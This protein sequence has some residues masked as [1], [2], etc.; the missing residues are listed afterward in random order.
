MIQLG[1]HRVHH[2]DCVAWMRALPANIADAIV[3]DPPYGLEFMGKGWDAPW[4]TSA[5]DKANRGTLTNMVNKNGSP[6]FKVQAPAFDLGAESSRAFQSWCTTWLTEALRVLK[7]GG[8]IVA[9]GGTRTYHRLACATEDAGFEI[10]DS[11]MWLQAQG[12]AKG[13]NVSKGI[14]KA[15]GAKRE[16]VE[17]RRVK[18]GGMEHVNRANAEP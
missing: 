13:L 1:Q 14:D 4:K 15:A 3:C 2:G 9:F 17:T 18:G 12:F 8:H 16:V 6:K 5:A 7:P 11:L 10:R